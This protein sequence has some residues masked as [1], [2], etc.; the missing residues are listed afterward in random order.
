MLYLP[1]GL[2]SVPFPSCGINTHCWR[3]CFVPLLRYYLDE[4]PGSDTTNRALHL[5]IDPSEL[6][7]I[8]NTHLRATVLLPADKVVALQVL[9]FSRAF[10]SVKTASFHFGVS[11][12][13]CTFLGIL[14]LDIL[15]VNA[16]KEG[17]KFEYDTLLDMGCILHGLPSFL[18]AMG[19]LRSVYCFLSS[20]GTSRLVYMELGSRRDLPVW[21]GSLSL[22][23]DS[24]L[25]WGIGLLPLDHCFFWHKFFHSKLDFLP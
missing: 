19:K 16:A 5:L 8:V 12:A 13:S 4:N 15:E 7:F 22:D 6:Y 9:F 1:S 11:R 21:V 23:S 10:I 2:C 20:K 24:W 18:K 25:S 14:T 3:L 17:D